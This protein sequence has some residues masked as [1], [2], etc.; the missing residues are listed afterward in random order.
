MFSKYLKDG[1]KLMYMITA[2]RTRKGDLKPED[3]DKFVNDIMSDF[4]LKM[5]EQPTL[6]LIPE[7]HTGKETYGEYIIVKRQAR[8]HGHYYLGFHTQE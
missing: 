8:P 3:C 1:D 6:L 5:G 7:D 4:E 2:K